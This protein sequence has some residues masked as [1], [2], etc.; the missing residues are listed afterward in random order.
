MINI[1]HRGKEKSFTSVNLITSPERRK[2]RCCQCNSAFLRQDSFSFITWLTFAVQFKKKKT[3]LSKLLEHSLGIILKDNRKIWNLRL[4]STF[5]LSSRNTYHFANIQSTIRKVN[6]AKTTYRGKKKCIQNF[7]QVE[8]DLEIKD[9]NWI[10]ISI[11]FK[12]NLSGRKRFNKHVLISFAGFTTLLLRTY[13]TV[14]YLKKAIIPKSLSFLVFRLT[15][16]SLFFMKDSFRSLIQVS[17]GQGT[18]KWKNA[19]YTPY[20]KKRERVFREPNWR[21][22][23]GSTL[24]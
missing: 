13:L 1:S 10:Y 12:K 18:D 20:K 14:N 21:F 17:K 15:C 6:S 16:F 5:F 11:K 24:Y 3:F 19:C 22:L 9:L 7:R 2:E 23:K 8:I 4:V